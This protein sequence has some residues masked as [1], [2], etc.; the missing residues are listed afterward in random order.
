ML[1]VGD[2]T[3]VVLSRV[4]NTGVGAEV[5]VG[6]MLMYISSLLLL[7]I[8]LLPTA[9]ASIKVPPCRASP[10]RLFRPLF[11]GFFLTPVSMGDEMKVEA[12][13]VKTKISSKKKP[14]FK[15][16]NRFHAW[17]KLVL[18]FEVFRSGARV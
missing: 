12:Q 11:L 13:P 4:D 5:F 15:I 2:N 18:I 3:V 16:K 10:R 1:A 17:A 6:L 9:L 14:R 8:L 7:L